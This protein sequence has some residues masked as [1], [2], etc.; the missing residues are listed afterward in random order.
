[1]RM[2]LWSWATTDL[3]AQFQMML[4]ASEPGGAVPGGSPFALHAEGFPSI[5]ES[6]AERRYKAQD[7]YLA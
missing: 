5:P 3:H 1:M 6:G 7:N 4:A 2:S